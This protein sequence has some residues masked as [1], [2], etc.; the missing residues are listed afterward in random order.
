MTYKLDFSSNATRVIAKWKKSN[1]AVYK[2]LNK[3]L[4]EL[5]DHPR[6]GLGHPEPLVGGDGITYSRRITA[7]HRIIYDILD[8]VVVVL[9]T[10]LEGHYNDK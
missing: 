7:Q 2:K 8:D 1:P 9:V 10:A 4:H 3:I 5:M 6:T